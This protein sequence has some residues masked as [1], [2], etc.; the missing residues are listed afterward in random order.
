[1][2]RPK[3]PPVIRSD[4]DMENLFSD[5][6]LEITSRKDHLA[7]LEKTILTFKQK[8][9]LFDDKDVGMVTQV[10]AKRTAEFEKLTQDFGAARDLY[11]AT[12]MDLES[13]IKEKEEL[14]RTTDTQ[15]GSISSEDELRVYFAQKQAQLQQGLQKAKSQLCAAIYN[16]LKPVPVSKS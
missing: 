8:P 14:L 15:Y 2:S 9:E 16:R 4:T 3:A 12:V 7:K 13:R 5:L 10:L 1:M 11:R 6:E